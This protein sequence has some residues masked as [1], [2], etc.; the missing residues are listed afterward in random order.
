MRRRDFI[1]V[2]GGTVAWPLAARAQQTM[3]VI[4][5]LHSGSP[6][7]FA[8]HAVAFRQ[9]LEETGYIEGQ[10]LLV[11]YR[12]AAGRYDQ[13]PALASDLVDR[14]VAEITATATDSVLAVKATRTTIPIVFVIGTDP[15][16][17]GLVTSLDRPGGNITG[18]SFVGNLPPLKLFDLLHELLPTAAKVGLLLNPADPNV[19]SNTRSVEV[20]ADAL[21]QTLVIVK[22]GTEK[23]FEPAFATFVHERVR[24]VF[25]DID[26]FVEGQRE[27]LVE[28]AARHAL[29]AIYSVREF[30]AVGGLMSYGTSLSDAHRQ[31]GIYSGRILRGEK[32]ANL[33]VG[34]PTRFELV[35][36]LK[37]AKALGFEIPPTLLARADEVIE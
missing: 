5:F 19:E 16:K 34:Q 3:P 28:L 21:G 15:I 30:A 36:N 4:G 29:P 32:P 17:L 33:P 10:N 13:L 35:I 7:S 27:Q 31:A 12:W 1:K 11:E 8:P 9:G 6:S 22:A 2:I 24:A 20:A 14:R 37:T 26:P 25:I 23:D 18:V